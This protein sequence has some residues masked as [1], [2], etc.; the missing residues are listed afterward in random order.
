MTGS[1]RRDVLRAGAALIAS[2]LSFS[3]LANAEHGDHIPDHVTLSFD[4]ETIKKYQPDLV[5][6]GVDPAP[7]AM[8]A[9]HAESEN[10]GL[11]AVYC[12]TLYPYQEGKTDHDSHLGDHEP[13]IVWY[14]AASGDVERVDYA[15]YHWFRGDA[16][17]DEFSYATDARNRPTFRVD[18]DYHH[19]YQYHGGV[20]G[21]RLQL[22]NLLESIDNWLNN[23]LE[24]PLALSQPY[25]PWQMFGRES[26]RQE[27][28]RTSV[29]L[30]LKKLWFN[31]GLSGAKET[32]DASEA[33][34]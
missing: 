22:E 15:A 31:L 34:W 30:A 28:S 19:Y 6:E 9:L 20:P 16:R 26:W 25:D 33:A 32:A 4:E 24:E 2:G 23:G 10:S 27:S 29:D 12:W 14:D 5:V 21:E 17:A 11:N 3:S 18:P 7:I 8:H 13:I 1:S